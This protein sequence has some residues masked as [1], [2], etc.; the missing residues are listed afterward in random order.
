MMVLGLKR[1]KSQ[2]GDIGMRSEWNAES[3]PI[4]GIPAA[5]GTS[6]IKEHLHTSSFSLFDC[7]RHATS[8]VFPEGDQRVGRWYDPTAGAGR[9]GPAVPVG[10]EFHVP[11]YESIPPPHQP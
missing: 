6:P 9:P 1:D 8:K 10:I 4:A 3:N 2:R 7:F 11:V 5:A